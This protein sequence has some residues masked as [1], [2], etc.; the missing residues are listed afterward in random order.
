M[1]IESSKWGFFFGLFQQIC[2]FPSTTSG[3]RIK[4]GFL[5]KNRVL[6]LKSKKVS[7]LKLHHSSKQLTVTSVTCYFAHRYT[8][9]LDS[10]CIKESQTFY[11]SCF[12]LVGVFFPFLSHGW[13]FW[14]H[15]ALLSKCVFCEINGLTWV[16]IKV[17]LS[18][19]R[20]S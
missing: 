8:K 14:K 19:V 4:L 6:Y 7:Y 17:G 9:I 15:S 11:I 20:Q 12:L 16:G 2:Y 5:S 10:S 3:T 18:L 13:N 1:D